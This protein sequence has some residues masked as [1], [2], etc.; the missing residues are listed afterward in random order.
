MRKTVA[1]LSSAIAVMALTAGTAVAQE[2]TPPSEV[3]CFPLLSSLVCHIPVNV[4]VGPFE[5]TGPF[6]VV[7]SVFPPPSP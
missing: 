3:T 2:E 1:V 4:P 6:V 7:E 5:F